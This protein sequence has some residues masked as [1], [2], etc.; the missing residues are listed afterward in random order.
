ME[1][2]IRS[3]SDKI[4]EKKHLG[5]AVSILI[6]LLTFCVNAWFLLT[7][8]RAYI[9]SDMASNF[10][11]AVNNNSEGTLLSKN[12]YYSTVAEIFR[13]T[14]VYQLVLLFIK[15][16][17]ALARTVGVLLMQLILV[18]TFLI[19][20]RMINLSRKNAVIS[21][22]FLISPLCYW[23]FLMIG[24]GAYYIQNTTFAL[25]TII[26]VLW[27]PKIEEKNVNLKTVI[28]ILL[29]VVTGII[30]GINGIKSVIFP[31]GPLMV[32]TVFIA[33]FALRKDTEKIKKYDC[34]E[35]KWL[36]IVI[37][38]IFSFGIG[39]ILN[40]VYISKNFYYESKDNISFA[41]FD[42]TKVFG[43]ISDCLALL[44]YQN[45]Q[46][47]NWLLQGKL[48]RSV[49]SLQGIANLFAI[50]LIAYL[51][52][53]IIRLI[54]RFN[55]LSNEQKAL[56]YFF[57]SAL[58]VGT[59]ILKFTEGYDTTPA[60]WIPV[61]PL[62]IA[63]LMLELET[64]DYRF[65]ITKIAVLI[66]MVICVSITS[67]S[68]VKL[69]QETP[70]YGN[71]QMDNIAKWLEDNGY[72]KGYATFWQ[73]NVLTYLT[74]GHIEMW[75]VYGFD[76]LELNKWLQKMSHDERPE[77]EKIFALIGPNDDLDREVFLQYMNTEPGTP[78]IVYQDDQGYIV[79]EYRK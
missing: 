2:L 69:Y 3:I 71:P 19:F 51:V 5:L 58:I 42:I 21:A 10:V 46:H 43:G 56:L 15:N 61:Y 47:L 65:D 16:N 28:C 49:F 37:V 72:E 44:G 13:D 23:L 55:V 36:K 77:G 38:S 17:W 53:S 35:W 27:Y 41:P 66:T 62:M 7:R 26:A 54:Q 20:A 68:S 11:A 67:I 34:F 39:Y 73:S 29:A 79:V 40:I 4:K 30:S 12:W 14:N 70:L 31:Y 6:L 25:L 74:D 8:G 48:S 33:F 22:A 60:Y 18:V 78:E 50:L 63:I 76:N 64:E 24:F 52:F 9:D 57:A 1:T 45:D 75:T 59:V 32:A